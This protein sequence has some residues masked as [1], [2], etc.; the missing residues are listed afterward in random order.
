MTF[1]RWGAVFAAVATA[2]ITTAFSSLSRRT[3]VPAAG[4]SSEIV[5]LA[6]RGMEPTT[7]ILVATVGDG[8]ARVR[9]AGR[10]THREEAGIRGVLSLDGRTLFAV[11]DRAP[12]RDRSYAGTLLVIDLG[13]ADGGAGEARALADSVAHASRPVVTSRGTLLVSRGKAGPELGDGRRRVDE[14][15]LTEIDPVTG[16]ARDLVSG[17][18]WELHLAALWQNEAIV[19][20][21]LPDGHATLLA[22]GAAGAQ[23]TLVETMSLVAR[24]FSVDGNS[25]A[26]TDHEGPGG[27]YTIERLDL[28]TG[29]RTR[30]LVAPSAHLAPHVWPGGGVAYSRPSGDGD[31]GLDVLGG[32]VRVRAPVGRGVDV[33]RA[34][35]RDG[36]LAAMW[37]YAPV[38]DGIAPEVV[39]VD[40][41]TGAVR[42]R[43][44][45][46][47]DV[48][49]EI[50]G[51]REAR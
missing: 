28:A 34:L 13:G 6:T 20:W 10:L 31:L 25:L 8:E 49:Y 24:D 47:V 23:R 7:E 37:H 1:R 29:A 35:S 17:A 2:A 22:V 3:E 38:S 50:V 39:V 26:W 30:L 5:L 44:T 43:L 11:V 32:A 14:L 4:P 27:Q 19:Y 21:K 45:P 12:G 33:V 48:R 15:R 16:A 41:T 46:P 42:A 36:R 18:G 40:T 9:T 51:L